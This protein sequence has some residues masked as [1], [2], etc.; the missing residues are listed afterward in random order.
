MRTMLCINLLSD[1][2]SKIS[3]KILGIPIK[4]VREQLLEGKIVRQI[5]QRE[6]EFKGTHA[7]FLVAQTYNQQTS[8]TLFKKKKKEK[9]VT[10]RRKATDGSD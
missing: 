10:K 8:A 3:R 7:R 2:F 5:V 9:N 4:L 1:P 6:L